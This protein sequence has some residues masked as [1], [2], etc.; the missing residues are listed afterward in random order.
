MDTQEVISAIKEGFK[1][2][3]GATGNSAPAGS[4]PSTGYLNNFKDQLGKVTEAGVPLIVGFNRLTQGTDAATTGL[5]LLSK[6]ASMVGFES[7]GAAMGKY[8][9]AVLEQKTNM[10]KASAELGIG[11]NNIGKFVRMSGEAGLTTAQF[12]EAI[13][14]SNGML[15]GLSGN[16]QRSAEVFSKVSKQI[17]ESAAGE[18]LQ[19][20]G[21]TAQEM[22]TYTALSMAN[23]TKKDMTTE[24]SQ[25]EAAA[26]AI[27]LATE[28]DATSKI[29]GQ[30]R[31]ALAKTL[32]EEEKKPNV[33]LMEMQ[34][35]ADQRAGYLKLKEQMAGFGPSFQSLSAE[36]ASGGVRTKEGLAQMAA[37]GPAG[38]EFE[39][40]TKMMTNAKTD[41]EKKNAQA[42]LEQAQAAI[43][44]RMA[45][46]EYNNM[47]QYGTAEQKAAIA[48]QVGDGKNLMAAQKAAQDANGD[49]AKA[50]QKQKAE[51]EAQ[52]K[53]KQVDDKGNIKVDE[54]GNALKDEGARTAEALNKANHQ[55]IIQAGGMAQNFEQI[56][57]ELGANSTFRKA[58]GMAGSSKTME[59]ARE[60]QKKAPA[61]IGNALANG[62]TGSNGPVTPSAAPTTGMSG[63]KIEKATPKEDGG[64]VPGT[65]GGTTLTIGEKGKPEAIVP[66][67]QAKSTGVPGA[68]GAA[69]GAKPADTG[70]GKGELEMVLSDY[71][72]TVLKYAAT[73]GEMKKVQLDNEKNIIRGTEAQIAESKQRIANIQ[74][75]AEGRELTTREQNRIAKI[76]DDIKGF[77]QEK[78]T[79]KEALAVFENIDR[80]KAQTSTDAKKAEVAEVTKA[81]E[82]KKTI[83]AAQSLFAQQSM[84]GL[85]EG[86]KKMF[87]DFYG[88]SKEDTEKK[89]A[90]LEE[91]RAAALSANQAAVK[92]RDALEDKAE[93]EG[94][95]LTE[96]EQAQR[97]AL[98]KEMNSSA[99]RVGA[100]DNAK[101]ALEKASQATE[102]DAKYNAQRAEIAQEAAKQATEIS[103][104][105]AKEQEAVQKEAVKKVTDNVKETLTINGKVTDP[106]SPEGKAA[107]AKIEEAKKTMSKV[108]GDVIPAKMPDLSKIKETMVK[109]EQLE[110]DKARVQKEMEQH[111][112]DIK[113]ES[114]TDK[115]NKMSGSFGNIGASVGGY[116]PFHPKI[117]DAKAA[118]EQK[119]KI[120][121]QK[122]SAAKTSEAT[123]PQ[124]K[125]EEK[126]EEKKDE[127]KPV[128]K[129]EAAA[130][131]GKDA[132]MNDLKEQLVQL[133]KHMT[134]LIN[135]SETTADAANKTAKNSAKFSGSRM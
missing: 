10:D 87:N 70:K 121:E 12:T 61:E 124:P 103:K 28:L 116:D 68:V 85:S 33:I 36:I 127:A 7:L 72:K 108:I 62:V 50:L 41:E 76:N 9:G 84:I 14:K 42:A 64:I 3:T 54:K 131:A 24:K 55:A 75:D 18:N 91:E 2:L 25:K 129:K 49:Y 34:M 83:T 37:L 119:A 46:K 15:A 94:R 59:E 109:P 79:H 17:N 11:S 100:A 8:G 26:A 95:K 21:I 123:K 88:M 63:G 80:L 117:V 111:A 112:K 22:A 97:A 113:P 130:P 30:S 27:E 134:Q 52:Q 47:M 78:A 128:E 132:T 90:S 56:N 69:T 102:A 115:F 19:A 58:L 35:S 106:N 1:S 125:A 104:V 114:I 66:L 122:A 105:N 31:E 86:Q 43:N 4:A 38:I 135:H 40:A 13:Q 67:D 39:K 29:S 96:A 53:G 89:K 32:Q 133:N 118:E 126:K 20:M 73:E 99:D 51:A 65:P 92:A 44:Q 82:Q 57:K 45:S 23:Q 110:A 81:E 16:A 60:T 6:A 5:A 98:T 101:R 93:L 71:Q 77:E 107:L 74:K 48:A 120:A